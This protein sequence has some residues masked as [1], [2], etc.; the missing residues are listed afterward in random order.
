MP[1]ATRNPWST[2]LTSA[3][4]ARPESLVVPAGE[5]LAPARAGHLADAGPAGVERSGCP[6]IDSIS[7]VMPVY[8][9]EGNLPELHRRLAIV[10]AKALRDVAHLDDKAIQALPGGGARWLNVVSITP[11]EPAGVYIIA[12][13]TPAPAL[14]TSVSFLWNTFEVIRIYRQL[15]TAQAIALL[16]QMLVAGVVQRFTTVEQW[17]KAFDLAL[18]DTVADQLQLLLPDELEVLINAFTAPNAATFTSQ[19]NATLLRLLGSP[20]RLAAQIAALNAVVQSDGSPIVTLEEDLDRY[21]DRNPPQLS[22][23]DVVALFHWQNA[24]YALPAF[25]RRLR[26]FRA[27]RGL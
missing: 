27:E 3:D 16:R 21:S 13:G 14:Q 5:P 19:L 10:L 2:T 22:E 9:E 12:W 6:V 8:Q 17:V 25:V 7:L 15:G 20:R 11:Q 18:C 26:A 4:I 24:G 23:S 1:C